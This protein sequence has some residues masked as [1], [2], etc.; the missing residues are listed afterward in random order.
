[1]LKSPKKRLQTVLAGEL[2]RLIGDG[3]PSRKSTE[4]YIQRLS[5]FADALE[6]EASDIRKITIPTERSILEKE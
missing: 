1:M 4:A 5:E 3:N 2:D 6:Q